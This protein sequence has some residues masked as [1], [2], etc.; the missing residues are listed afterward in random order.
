MNKALQIVFAIGLIVIAIAVFISWRNDNKR[1]AEIEA[2]HDIKKNV[3]IVAIIDSIGRIRD[4]VFI[5]SLRQLKA[6][7]DSLGLVQNTVNQKLRKSNAALEEKVRRL[8][9]MLGGRPVF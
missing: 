3:D 2:I 1:D 5:D 4:R 7:V 9:A 6:Q 8:D